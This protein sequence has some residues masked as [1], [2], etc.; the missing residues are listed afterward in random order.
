MK[1]IKEQLFK[2]LISIRS[3]LKI[4]FENKICSE[5]F[6]WSI[7]SLKI[8]EKTENILQK[9]V[10]AGIKRDSFVKDFLYYVKTH[11]VI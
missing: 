11:E 2:E 7:G 9:A 10:L 8:K 5:E 4:S 1:S 6:F 3:D